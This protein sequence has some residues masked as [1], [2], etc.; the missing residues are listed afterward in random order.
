[1]RKSHCEMGS[2]YE[3]AFSHYDIGEESLWHHCNQNDPK[4]EEESSG[5]VWGG[6]SRWGARRCGL[7]VTYL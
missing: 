5:K 2:H 7:M 6:V 3:K 4:E 1:M